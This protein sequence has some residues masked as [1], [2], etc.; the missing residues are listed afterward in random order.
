VRGALL[1]L[2]FLTLARVAAA[3]PAFTPGGTAQ[4]RR[5]GDDAT[6]ALADGRQ[7]RLVDIDLP[8][9]GASASAALAALRTLLSG[10]AAALRFA[11]NPVDRQGRVLAELYVGPVWVEGELLRRGLARVHSEADERVGVA[12]MLALE[13]AA[14]Q[15]RLGLWADRTYRVVSADAAGR[16]A[17][18]FQLV[19]GKLVHVGRSAEAVF[20]DFGPPRSRALVGIIEIPALKLFRDAKLDPTTLAGK[21]VRLRGF[22]DG[23]FRPRMAITHPE[24]IEV[25]AQ[26]KAAP[27]RTPEPP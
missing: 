20:L 23:R 15:R 27:A 11:G 2:L 4:I 18:S 21:N 5:I 19:S 14:R 26:E 24:Q 6:I 8:R 1:A 10:G 13:D 25:P 16:F 12:E 3:D 17:G 7:L 9:R 22:I